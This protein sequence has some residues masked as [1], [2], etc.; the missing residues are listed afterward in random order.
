M[1]PSGSRGP[2]IWTFV[3]FTDS[4]C[5]SERVSF[6]QW[7]RLTSSASP[8]LLPQI[9]DKG[10]PTWMN[11]VL[12]KSEFVRQYYCRVGVL[13]RGENKQ[14][15]VLGTRPRG[16]SLQDNSGTSNTEGVRLGIFFLSFFFFFFK[17]GFPCVALA[18]LELSL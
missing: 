18:V 5:F 9:A 1:L 12:E 8:V 17:T 3:S 4:I 2:F 7:P 15:E 10:C 11:W 6:T 13:V 14:T 16:E